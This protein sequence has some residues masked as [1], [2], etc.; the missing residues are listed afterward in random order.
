[1]TAYFENLL[2]SATTFSNMRL[3]SS[4]AC[5]LLYLVI[6]LFYRQLSLRPNPQNLPLF[7]AHLEELYWI[8]GINVAWSKFRLCGLRLYQ[9]PPK[10]K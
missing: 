6:Y 9:I 2:D 10:N 8:L 7:V 1:M 4:Q 5:M 3:A